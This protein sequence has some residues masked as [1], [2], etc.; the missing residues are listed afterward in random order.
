MRVPDA[1]IEEVTPQVEPAVQ[2][3]RRTN[4]EFQEARQIRKSASTEDAG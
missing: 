4:I 3:Y 2:I 1:I